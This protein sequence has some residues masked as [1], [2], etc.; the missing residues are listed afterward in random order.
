VKNAGR[1]TGLLSP[2]ADPPAPAPPASTPTTASTYNRHL[3]FFDQFVCFSASRSGDACWSRF[4]AFW[5]HD[6]TDCGKANGSNGGAR[7]YISE[8]LAA[9][10]IHVR[11][12]FFKA[13]VDPRAVSGN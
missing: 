7:Q 4:G 13:L 1:V 12:P 11:A 8:H 9:T 3:C 10:R 5:R 6:P 2:A